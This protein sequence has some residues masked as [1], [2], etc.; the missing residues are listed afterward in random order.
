MANIYYDKDADMSLLEGKKIAVLGYGSQGHAHSLNLAN[1]GADVRVG[2]Y[3]GSKSWAAAEAAGLKVMETGAACAEADVIMILLPDTSQA[4]VYKESIEPNLKPGDTIMFGHGF[5]IRY[6]QIV[7]PAFVDVSMVAPKSPGHRVREL[8][9]EG[10]G[11]PAL[12]AVHQDASGQAKAFALAY[13]RAIGTT[14]AGVIETT[15]PE[16]TETDLFGEQA[17]LCGGVTA[18]VEA[19]FNTLVEAGYQPEIAYFECMHELKLIVDLMYQGGMSY[20]RY[21]ISDTAE[22][23]DYS[24]G[25]KI[26]T[27]DT[28]ATMKQMLQDIRSGSYAEAWIDENA[29]GRPWF[30]QMR[31][32]GRTSKIEQ[33]G[34]KLRAMMPW[35][36]PKEV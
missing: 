15:F 28:R 8:Y 32:N 4:A 1:S 21:S 11:T 14:R 36:N 10:T 2:L 30:N 24:A 26:I 27:D 6:G 12:V 33:V 13:A 23:G 19:G 25:S 17:V 7:P 3:E 22:H 18:L 31:E 29:N 34:K 35:L 5:N 20:M 16:E 9:V